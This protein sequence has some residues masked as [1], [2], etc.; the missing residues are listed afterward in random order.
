MPRTKSSK[1]HSVQ[2]TPLALSELHIYLDALEKEHQ[3]LLKQIKRK[4]TELKNFVEKMRSLATEIFHRATPKLKQMTDIDQEIHALFAEIFTTRKLGKQSLKNIKLLYRNLQLAG[5]ISPKIESQ[6]EDTEIDELFEN[7]RQEFDFEEESEEN[8]NQHHQRQQEWGDN[9]ATRKDESRKIRQTFLRLAEIF[10]PDKVKDSE[11]QMYHTEIMKEINKA[12]QEGDLARLLEIERQH[13]LGESIDNNSEDDLTRRCKT[14][15]QQ[16]QILKNQYENLKRELR[17][18][19]HTPEGAMVADHRKAAKAGVDSVNQML[20]EIES[21]MNIVTE[22][23]DFVKDFKE[24][25]ITIQEFLNGPGILHD[26][27]QEIMADI[28]EQMLS[29]LQGV[30]RF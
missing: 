13:E 14:L 11:T 12:Y 9:S 22:I 23:R 17:Q 29:E 8:R 7:L 1:S 16:N 2:A 4:R 25:K 19:K 27:N 30:V 6:Q 5:V 26:L 28:L 18:A 10:H 24:Q 21:Q 15:E 3:S 20:D